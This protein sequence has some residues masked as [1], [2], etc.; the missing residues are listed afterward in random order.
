VRLD[1]LLVER[2][3]VPS[4]ERAQRLIMAGDVLVDDH[5]VSKAGTDVAEDAVVRLR[6]AASAYASRGGEKL[7]GALDMFGLDLTDRIVVD[8]GAST[9]GFTDVCLR[10]GARRVIAVDVG[11]GQLAW[12]LRQ[13]P[14]VTV[15]DRTNA[16]SLEAAM[17]PAPPD[18]AVVDVSFISLTIVLPAVVRVLAPAGQ[19]VA[20]VK[21]QFEVG[22]GE[23]GKGGVVRD[24][25][26]RAAAVSSVRDA[27][28]RL[29]CAI[30]GEAESVLSGPKGNRE[31]FLW[32][33]LGIEPIA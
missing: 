31:V 22:K 17:M 25:A 1:R 19:I 9:G 12:S 27:M 18:V 8:V 5:V 23:V 28:A 20:L 32:G 15:L 24:P 30:R 26:K 14:R 4:R 16:R 7:A 3:L 33:A 13:D 29:G 11:Y 6:A 10:R 2:G 21:P